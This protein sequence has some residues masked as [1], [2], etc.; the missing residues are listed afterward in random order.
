MPT[1]NVPRLPIF[2]W[3][4][5]QGGHAASLPSVLDI[6]SL[7][8]TSSGRAAIA[9]A[10]REMGVGVGDRILVPT[11]HCPTMVAPIVAIG[12]QPLFYPISASGAPQFD[13]IAAMNLGAVRG[14]IAAHYFGLPQPMRG[15]REFCDQRGISLIEDCAHAM[16]GK[17]DGQAIGSWGDYAIASLTKF[18]SVLEGGCL[19]SSRHRLREAPART[20]SLRDEVR[21]VVDVLETAVKFRRLTGLNS[22]LAALFSLKDMFRHRDKKGA[23]ILSGDSVKVPDVERE[24]LASFEKDSPV[25]SCPN[26]GTRWLAAHA[27]R[28]RIIALRRRNYQLLAQQLADIPGAHPLFPVLAEECAPYVFPLAVDNP[29][30]YYQ[31]LR[32]SGVPV[33]RWDWRWPDTP[34]EEG[35]AGALWSH[36]VFQIGCHQDLDPDNIDAIVN[37]IKGLLRDEVSN[38]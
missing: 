38:E 24:G 30:R 20:K 26:R 22:V 1:L 25:W 29:D 31:R 35:D 9:F 18:F 36:Q 33:F 2:G 28:E 11:Y 21:N 7:V 5:I 15:V 12:A 23:D 32:A 16:F 19:V 27:N 4:T 13:R 17:A 34:E 8:W 37:T 10:L 6:P 3:S 14:M